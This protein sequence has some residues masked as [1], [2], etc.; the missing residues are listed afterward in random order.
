MDPREVQIL[1]GGSRLQSRV[2][3]YYKDTFAP[4]AKMTTIY[5]HVIEG[6]GSWMVAFLAGLKE[7]FS[8]K[9]PFKEVYVQSL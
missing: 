3:H 2:W 6:H 4:I 7:C 1:I 5:T 8:S 9:R